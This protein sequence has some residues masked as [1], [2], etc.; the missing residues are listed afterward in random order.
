M[1]SEDHTMF[2]LAMGIQW[3]Q[4]KPMFRHI[5]GIMA[6][7]CFPDMLATKVYPNA[8]ELTESA[9]AFDVVRNK[10][11]VFAL[12]DPGVTLIAVADGSTPRTAAMFAFRTRWNCISIDPNL[13]HK[14]WENKI[15]RLTLFRKKIEDVHPMHF[16]KLVI[17]AVHS[18][19]PF[20]LVCERFTADE[21][22]A[23]AIP[24]CY[25]QERERPP[26]LEYVD[27]GIWSPK[28][29]VKVWWDGPPSEVV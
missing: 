15:K 12:N 6:N 11:P 26:D 7:A 27:I 17:A 21:R 1:L 2:P 14:E 19:A 18:H 8:K 13:N 10:M 16:P 9:A 25:V 28:N 4:I 3:K 5:N 23:I 22:L 20:D 24:C 29:V